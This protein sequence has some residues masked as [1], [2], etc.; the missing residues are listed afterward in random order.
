MGRSF[1]RL[2]FTEVRGVGVFGGGEA[3]TKYSV[4]RT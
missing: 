1:V 3:E 4:L 2:L